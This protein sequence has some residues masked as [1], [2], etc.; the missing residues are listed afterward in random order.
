MKF[1]ALYSRG[2]TLVE[3]MI[4]IA[5]IGLLSGI[6]ITSLTGSKAKSRDARRISDINQI[7]LALEQ[8]FDRCGQYP[9]AGANNLPSTSSTCNVGGT[10][11]NINSYISVIPIDP[12]NDSGHKYSYVVNSSSYPTDYVLHATLESSNAAQQNSFSKTAQANDSAWATSF[13]CYD[14]ST[15]PLDY[16]VSTH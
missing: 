4:V 8:Y 6:I 11:V 12:T 2:F 10:T 15:N 13:T 14:S 3:L 5:I 7:Q 16:C 1:K 9:A